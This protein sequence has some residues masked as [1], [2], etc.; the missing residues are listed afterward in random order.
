[1]DSET[2]PNVIYGG[3]PYEFGPLDGCCASLGELIW[4]NLKKGGDNKSLVRSAINYSDK[5]S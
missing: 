4:S 1:M 5:L 3:D 2:D